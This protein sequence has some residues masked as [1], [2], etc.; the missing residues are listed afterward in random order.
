MISNRGSG[1]NPLVKE[2]ALSDAALRWCETA[3]AEA[4]PPI[5]PR[6]RL[7]VE[8]L[9]V[10]ASHRS[11]YRLRDGEHTWVFMNSPPELERN[12]AFVSLAGVFAAHAVPVPIIIDRSD[13]PGWFLLTDLGSRHLED[14][15]GT[16]DEA[17]AIEA[18]I[19]MLPRL[20]AISDPAIEPYTEARFADELG[21][22]DEWF[23]RALLETD[24]LPPP[25]AAY[26]RLIAATQEQP[27]GCVHRDYHCR[28]LLYDGHRLGIV[29]FQDALAGPLLYDLASLL[30]DC[31]YTFDE[32][33]VDRHLDTYLSL[34]D[35]FAGVPRSQLR[36]WLDYTA[37]QR[38]LK[39]IG[40][41]ARLAL[42]DGKRTHLGYIPPL[43]DRLIDLLSGYPALAEL[44]KQLLDCRT[45]CRA[46]PERF[47]A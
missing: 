26:A 15:Y 43:L 23:V 35:A 19:A 10:E 39:A 33:T 22:F 6:A 40:I 30:R 20:A 27:Q 37:V 28:N 8:P 31:Y 21:L 13:E 47:I 45:L 44:N 34:S 16:A 36:Q 41:F 9:R 38:Q 11:F 17:R 7:S 14:T 3:L 5:A 42:R 1:Y 24:D 2:I 4:T 46:A 29:D 32:A 12:D 18:A 25:D